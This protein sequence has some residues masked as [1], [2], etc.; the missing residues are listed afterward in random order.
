MNEKQD[1]EK[2]ESFLAEVNYL[3]GMGATGFVTRRQRFVR[4]LM[5]YPIPAW[6]VASLN[7]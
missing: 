6:G 1:K 3:L 4:S 2:F 7:P 5:R